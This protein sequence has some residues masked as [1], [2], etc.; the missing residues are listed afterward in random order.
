MASL[1]S[2]LFRRLGISDGILVHDTQLLLARYEGR[3][4]SHGRAELYASVSGEVVKY[5]QHITSLMA[6]IPSG[7]YH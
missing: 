7:T 1:V 5:P 2:A 6:H 3:A 4:G